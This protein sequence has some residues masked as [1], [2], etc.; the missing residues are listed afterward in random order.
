MASIFILEN[1]ED[2]SFVLNAW[3][4]KNG[5]DVKCFSASQ[6]IFEEI[7]HSTPDIILLDLHL[8]ENSMDGY[9]VCNKLK[10]E[11]RYPNKVFLMSGVPH[12]KE[13]LNMTCIDG[14]IEKPFYLKDVFETIDA[15]VKG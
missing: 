11:Y 12:T 4:S 9:T 6:Q 1:N 13:T 15:A 8:Q 10:G 3:F 2:I 14:F 7:K 5:Y